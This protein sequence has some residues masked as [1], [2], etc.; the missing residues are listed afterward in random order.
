MSEFLNTNNDSGLPDGHPVQVY[1][2]ENQL[3]RDI[4]ENINNINI[5]DNFSLSSFL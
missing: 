3:I 4:I 1:M 2:D 5:Q